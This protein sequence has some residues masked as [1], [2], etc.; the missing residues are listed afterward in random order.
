MPY[1]EPEK[2]EEIRQ[3]H[4]DIKMEEQIRIPLVDNH[5]PSLELCRFCEHCLPAGACECFPWNLDRS[6]FAPRKVRPPLPTLPFPVA[7]RECR[8][9][10]RAS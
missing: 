9:D 6:V 7:R 1:K 4:H 8:R 10:T 3:M 5:K 2:E